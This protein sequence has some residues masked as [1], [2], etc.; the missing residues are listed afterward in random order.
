MV[1]PRTFGVH[2]SPGN[3]ID[4]R[5]LGHRPRLSPETRHRLAEGYNLESFRKDIMA[6]LTVA[7]V[8]LPL[9]MAI[10]AGLGRAGV[11]C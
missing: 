7:I 5:R 2:K 10:A 3:A 11:D 1:R 8:A 9:S 4:A 6:A